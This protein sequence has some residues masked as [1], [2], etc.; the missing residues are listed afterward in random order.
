MKRVLL[1]G[2]YGGFGA[3][4]AR[5][6]SDGDTHI[7]VAGRSLAK[8]QDFA[9]TL[10]NASGL[11]VDRNGDIAAVL[12]EHRP[13]LVIDAAGPF[14]ASSYAVP[15]ACIGAR[16]PYTDLAD[17]RDFVVDFGDLDAAAKTAGVALVSGASS[18]P[19]LSGAV[20]RA[21]SQA[22][23]RVDAVDMA[24]N[25][26]NRA[27][28]GESVARA[29]L[30]YA[31]QPVWLW[32]GKRWHAKAGWSELQRVRFEA[33][34]GTELKGRWLA[35]ADIPDHALMPD[36][37]PG[38]PAVTFR[39]GTELCF[40]MT[41]LW[42]ASFLV[43][44]K[45]VRS[46]ERFAPRILPFIRATKNWGGDRSAMHVI[47][48]GRRDGA[49]VERRWTLIAEQGDG[50]E[51]PTLAAE[52]VARKLLAGALEPGARDASTTLRLEEFAPLFD[53]L[54][55]HHGI[56]E[57]A[58]PSPVYARALGPAYDRL[59]GA[60]RAMHDIIADGGAEGEGTVERGGNPFARLVGAVMR[61]PPSGTYP[62]DVDFAES[63]GK[64]R[65]TRH[66]GA[67]HFSSEL[68]QDGD[69]VI[70]RFGPIRF[71]FALPSDETGLEMHLR[72]WTICGIPLPLALAPCIAAR[73]WEDEQR[74][75]RFS[76]AVALPVIGRVVLYQGWLEQ[77]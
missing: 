47:V 44:W 33:P 9:A 4:L 38:K 26:S 69:G 1:I 22:M 28:S 51:I 5:R 35:L 63:R 41:G 65:W 50:P 11:A 70:E 14:Q 40:Q 54:A 62:L 23:S 24:I 13:D 25:A 8:A 37:L 71:S 76:V 3:R 67:H 31:G 16:I 10:P 60:V 12:A 29:A 75:F 72:R 19:A 57:T 42:L 58:L 68:S 15:E 6:L 27:S 59:P 2:G 36:Q 61:F 77:S 46:L 18:V 20:V 52:L 17:A 53:R 43:R 49:P 55:L 7:I 21:L 32:R 45:L 39:A 30:S 73:E 64:E 34:D 66:F 56:S 48:K 74:R